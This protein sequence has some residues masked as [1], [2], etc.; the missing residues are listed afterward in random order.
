M[1]HEKHVLT[2]LLTV[3]SRLTF[4][5]CSRC[6]MRRTVNFDD[7]QLSD[8]NARDRRVRC[9]HVALGA[10]CTI[11]THVALDARCEVGK[12]THI[13]F[14]AM[15]LFLDALRL[16]DGVGLSV[17][18]MRLL[19]IS[20]LCFPPTYLAPHLWESTLRRRSGIVA[21]GSALRGMF[22]VRVDRR[23]FMYLHR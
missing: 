20:T 3:A 1:W 22:F 14:D 15:R 17:N 13:F 4:L 21:T 12:T 23:T 9:T 6:A 11:A 18:L 2:C 19:M 7:V 16:F 5:Y 10:R 8:C